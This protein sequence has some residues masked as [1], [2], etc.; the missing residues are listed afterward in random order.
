M[1]P[2]LEDLEATRSRKTFLVGSALVLND[3]FCSFRNKRGNAST[4]GDSV[5]VLESTSWIRNDREASAT[6]LESKAPDK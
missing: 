6:A 4:S 5:M 2:L 3:G 1:R